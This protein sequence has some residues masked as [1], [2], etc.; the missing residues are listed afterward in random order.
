MFA[1]RTVQAVLA[2]MFY[3]L[4]LEDGPVVHLRPFLSAIEWECFQV[5]CN[6]GALIMIFVLRISIIV[7]SVRL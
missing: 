2:S 5:E 7:M 4:V 3:F 1:R 6:G